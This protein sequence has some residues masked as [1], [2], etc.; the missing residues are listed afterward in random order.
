MTKL[1]ED[2]NS[3]RDICHKASKDAGWWTDG[4][5]KPLQENPLKAPA[6]MMLIVSE[7]VEM[8]EAHRK[9]AMDNHLTSRRGVEVAAAAGTR[10]AGVF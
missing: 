9:S 1:A 2:L 10:A 4:E 8:M 5:G 6:D 3:I 7:I